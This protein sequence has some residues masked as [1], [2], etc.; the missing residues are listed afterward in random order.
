M[1][2]AN[3]HNHST[4]SDGVYTPE[5]LVDL[6]VK[7]GH[8]ALILT[9][10][11]TVKGNY[12]LQKAARKAGLLSL[13]GCEFTTLGLGTDFHLVGIDFNPENKE[14]RELLE[15]ASRKLTSRTEILFQWGL[16][17]GTLRE[18]LTWQEVL[19]MFPDNDVFCNNHV[20]DALVARGIYVIEEYNDF[21]REN[22]GYYPEREKIIAQMIGLTNPDI[23]DVVKIIRNA[24]GVPVVAHP[25]KKEKYVEALIEMGVMGFETI[26]PDLNVEEREYYDRLC[27]ERNL[28]KLGGT[29]HHSV[30]GGYADRIPSHNVSPE[31]GYVTEENFMKLYRRELG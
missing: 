8:K 25:H 30:L 31:R 16:E 22:F 29:D 6:A 11:D 1:L 5:Q 15:R 2:F 21:F 13:A 17:N 26:H 28:Y 14:M 7:L 27:E 12:F 19:D 9:D 20:F 4:F 10:H 24:G 23:A 3:C 18:G